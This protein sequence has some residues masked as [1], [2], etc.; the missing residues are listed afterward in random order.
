VSRDPD[1]IPRVLELLE[2]VWRLYP[3]Q[4]LGQILLNACRDV[5][6]KAWPDVWNVEEPELMKGLEQMRHAAAHQGATWVLWRQDDNGNTFVVSA[7]ESPEETEHARKGYEA[8]G[9]KQR[10]WVEERRP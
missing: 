10:Y 2:E 9:H 6:G 3:D 8:R 5:A 1:R 4:R 7:I